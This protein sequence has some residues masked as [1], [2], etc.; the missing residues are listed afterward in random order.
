MGVV[1]SLTTAQVAHLAGL[2]RIELTE[3]ELA[4]LPGQLD[5]IL[6][7]VA[8]VSSAATADVEPTSH[9]LPLT[10]VWRDDEPRPCLTAAAALAMAPDSQD[11][12]FRV[13]HI[14]QE[15]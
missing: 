12:F 10:N 5:G 9:A 3:A 14:L 6:R 15:P 2:A 8:E 4:L 1:V 13:P 7:A 11:G